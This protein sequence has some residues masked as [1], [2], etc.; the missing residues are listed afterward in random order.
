MR[1]ARAAKLL[2]HPVA[3]PDAAHRAHR[4]PA[5]GEQRPR[6]R[7]QSA[8]ED[9][10]RAHHADVP[11]AGC[12]RSKYTRSMRRRR[13]RST[14]SLYAPIVRRLAGARHA[15]ERLVHE[16]A[17]GRDVVLREVLA[18]QLGELVERRRGR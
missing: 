4:H 1:R 8:S 16:A 5:G 14:T 7:T 13:T 2:L 15:A 9:R 3:Q 12:S 10:V 18:E 11:S 17:D 6:S